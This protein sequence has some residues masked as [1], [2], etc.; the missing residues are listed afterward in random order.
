M[1]KRGWR[2]TN[3]RLSDKRRAHE[4][5]AALASRIEAALRGQP[6]ASPVTAP[7]SSSQDSTGGIDAGSSDRHG[8]SVP[9]PHFCSSRSDA[10]PISTSYRGSFDE[11]AA[12]TAS[13]ESKRSALAKFEEEKSARSSIKSR[14]SHWKTWQSLHRAW[15][16]DANALPLTPGKIACVSALFKAGSY[17]SFADY[18]GR[19]KAE[20]IAT[21]HIHGERWTEELSV[22]VRNA[23][24]SVTRGLGTS[25]QSSPVDIQKVHAL[26]LSSDP[27]S[28]GGPISPYA[29]AALGVFFLTR[30]VE[31]TCAGFADLRLDETRLE[32][33][34]RL[35]VSKSDQRALGTSRMWGCVCSG[36]RSL[37]CPV[38]AYMDH[39]STLSSLA[40]RLGVATSALPLFPDEGGHE[41]S[42]INAVATI[43]ELVRRYGDAVTDVRGRN[44]YGGHSLRTG[45]AVTLAGLGLDSV[46]IECLARWHSPMLAHYARLA[47]LRTLTQEYKAKALAADSRDGTNLIT[48]RLAKLQLVVD[49]L[50]SRL[51]RE[52]LVD[53]TSESHLQA[54]TF[55]LNCVSDIWHL[56]AAH[57]SM[58]DKGKTICKWEYSRHNSIQSSAEPF[59]S[60]EHTFCNRCLPRLAIG[61]R[62]KEDITSSSSSASS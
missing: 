55:V 52:E 40:Q 1:V 11:A 32:L 23:T 9:V 49:G 61:S 18:I 16:N 54:D 4:P 3:A 29:F 34:W 14:V 53:E 12:A 22:S 33:T 27:L 60:L 6:L 47:P 17:C 21:F 5:D 51:D 2:L 56:S 44:L 31:I 50:V 46:R 43:T 45:G 39:S 42:K 58:T 62:S 10:P 26:N 24:R 59:A 28:L 20:H 8:S 37:V 48:E 57:D 30:E 38:H 25:R 15:F 19:A 7:A 41:V 35:P 36:D 13:E